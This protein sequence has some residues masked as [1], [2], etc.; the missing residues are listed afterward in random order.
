VGRLPL[1]RLSWPLLLGSK[2]ITFPE[3]IN[4]PLLFSDFFRVATPFITI[5]FYIAVAGVIAI[6]IKKMRSV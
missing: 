1:W 3:A 4:I 6:I 2:M 5:S